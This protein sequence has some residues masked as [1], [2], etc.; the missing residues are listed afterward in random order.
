MCQFKSL[1][2]TREKTYHLLDEDSHEKIIEHYG[3]KD[4]KDEI[5]R[6]EIVPV[7]YSKEI[8]TDPTKWDYHTDQEDDYVPS[9]YNAEW[10]EKEARKAMQETIDA[11]VVVDKNVGI[12][13]KGRWWLFGSSRAELW[14]S[15][16]A[17]LCESSRAVLR[18]SSRAVLWGSSSAVLWGSSRAVLRESSSAELWESS[19]A[20]L[21]GSSRAELRGAS[22]AELWESSSAVLCGSSRAELRGASSA[23]LRDS[24]SAV[25]WESS[26]A[27][28]HQTKMV[29]VPKSYKVETHE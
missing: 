26:S 7:A 16:S 23:E 18:D 25:L 15:S 2:I 6:A 4:D 22:S 13:K 1:I 19:R 10:A 12:I 21:C 14:E 27:V 5:V 20:V 8:M 24:S 17:V 11:R 9:W 3:L 29:F 28:N